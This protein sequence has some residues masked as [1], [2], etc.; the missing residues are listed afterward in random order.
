MKKISTGVATQIRN[1]SQQQ[2]TT[3]LDLGDR[4]S[5]Y[6]ARAATWAA[7][8]G[9]NREDGTRGKG[10]RRCT[11]ARK[12]IPICE[13][14]WFKERSTFWDRLGRTAICAAGD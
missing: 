9:C 12:G 1:F 10:S 7:I 3:G 11:S 8:S 6:C 2:L 5:W 4:S 14:C 13:R